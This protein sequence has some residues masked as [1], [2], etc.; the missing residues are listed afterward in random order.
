MGINDMDSGPLLLYFRKLE[1]YL[2]EL[3]KLEPVRPSRHV[4]RS[5]ST[6]P[7]STV[8]IHSKS[9]NDTDTPIITINSTVSSVEQIS[10][11]SEPETKYGRGTVAL[12]SCAA[13]AAVVVVVVIF[14]IGCQRFRKSHIYNQAATQES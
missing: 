9:S 6:P 12:V 10:V 3:E 14:V 7:T 2:A 8:R 13:V 1:S 4:A 5:T 11:T